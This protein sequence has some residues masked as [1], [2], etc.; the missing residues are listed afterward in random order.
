MEKAQKVNDIKCDTP[1]SE[2]CRIL[3]IL[4][5]FDTKATKQMCLA[6]LI[7]TSPNCTSMHQALSR[8]CTSTLGKRTTA[9]SLIVITDICL[10]DFLDY[11]FN[12]NRTEVNIH[13]T[14]IVKYQVNVC[15]QRK[16]AEGTGEGWES[17]FQWLYVTTYT[18]MEHHWSLYRD[19]NLTDSAYLRS[20]EEQLF[21]NVMNTSADDSKSHTREYICIISLSRIV[22]LTIICNRRKRRPT[23]KNTSSL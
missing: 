11:T 15:L 14:F 2:S 12:R 20:Y 8:T 9:M 10:W 13:L 16:G 19:T 5:C 7:Q 1:L 17:R 4:Q 23:S 21:L 3:F 6:G 18:A 22:C